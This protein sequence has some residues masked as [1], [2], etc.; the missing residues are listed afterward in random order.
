VTPEQRGPA[1]YAAF[2]G[3]SLIWGSTFLAIRFGNDTIPPLWGATLRLLLAA[4]LLFVVA[5]MS[6]VPFP[7]GHAL[8]GAA[9]FGFLNLGLNFSLLYWGEQRVASGIAAVL[10]ATVPLTAGVFAWIFGLERFQKTKLIGAVIGL[11]GVALIFAGELKLGAPEVALLAV[12]LGATIAALSTI[13]LKR[14]PSQSPFM[15]NSV[16]A[17]AGIPVCLLGSL[18]L[19]EPHPIPSGVKEWWPILYLVVAGNLGAY[20]LYA[21]LVSRWNVT[22]VSTTAL[23]VPVLAVLLGSLVRGESPAPETYLGGLVVL[24]GVTM[25]LRVG[26][27]VA[28]G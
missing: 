10:Y 13:V 27:K 28:P 2:A 15:T 8:R 4:P 5:R 24:V 16:G 3:M 25:A 7:K 18:F 17:L 21:W 12:F 11:A 9:L 26:K 20:V 19:H 1:E 14:T 6:G 23:I 22:T